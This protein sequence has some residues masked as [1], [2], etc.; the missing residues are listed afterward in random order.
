MSRLPFRLAP[1]L[2]LLAAPLAGQRVPVTLTASLTD[3]TG[4]VFPVSGRFWFVTLD[5]RDSTAGNTDGTGTA[6][7]DLLPGSYR[8]RSYQ[9]A[10]LGGRAYYWDL[11]LSVSGPTTVELSSA[12]AQEAPPSGDVIVMDAPPPREDAGSRRRGFWIGFGPAYGSV[13]S[14][15][16][17]GWESVGGF[18]VHLGGTVS[19]H[20]RIGASSDT[21][22]RQRDGVG[23]SQT[24]LTAVIMYFPSTT[25]GLRF[26]GGA[27]V[28]GRGRYETDGH[29]FQDEEWESGA[30]YI[31]GVAWEFMV[32]RKFALVPYANFVGGNFDRGHSNFW[33]FGLAATWP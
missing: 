4:K 13:E 26:T 16:N 30:G 8:I 28:T 2:L 21:W 15:R 32:A 25:L 12:N 7:V 24:S 31:A 19:P 5:G 14:D 27:G 6:R 3:E 18:S 33:L 11:P 9:R 23:H 20:I 1:A 29:E 22:A 17:A 10:S